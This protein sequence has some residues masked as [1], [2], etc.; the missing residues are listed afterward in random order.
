MTAV[1][2]LIYMIEKGELITPD[3]K[4]RLLELEKLQLIQAYQLDP[5]LMKL[6]YNN[7][8]AWY[9]DNYGY[10]YQKA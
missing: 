6:R 4:K 10:K 7:A 3:D 2:Q 1:K 8:Q 9:K 5:D